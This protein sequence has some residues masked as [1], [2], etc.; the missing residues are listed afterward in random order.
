MGTINGRDFIERLDKLE[1]EIW[2]DGEK[3]KGKISEHPAFKGILRSKAS[4]YDLQNDPVLKDQMTYFL[5]ERGEYVG[6]SYLQPKTKGDLWERRRMMEH[7]ARSTHGLMG[8]SPDYMNTAVM[9]LATSSSL[10]KG[11]E[12]C[13]PENIQSLYERAIEQDLSFTHT[14]IAPQVNRSQDYLGSSEEPIS[15]KVIDRNKE[16]IVIKG[17]RLLATQGGLTDEVLVISAPRLFSDMDEAFAFSIPSNT[18]GLKFICRQSFVGGESSFNHPLSSRY[19]EID[20]VVVFDN[21]LVPWDRVF[22]YDNVEVAADFMNTSSFYPFAYHQVITRQIVKAEF[23]LGVAELLVETINV[24]EYQHI[25]EKLSEIIIGLETLKALLEKSENDAE[26]DEFG[27]MRPSMIPLQVASN[28]SPRIFPRFSEIIQLIGASGMV[29][30]PT[31]KDFSSDIRAD[32]DKYLQGANTNAED[33]VK[34]FR[35]A[36]DLT[37]SSFGTR[38]THYERYFF[39]DPVRLSNVLYKKYLKDKHVENISK[40]LNLKY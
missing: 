8:R 29:S 18:K 28:L 2:F 35:L 22:F 31:E 17:A 11:R 37:M 34:I 24:S 1:N 38:Q 40:L 12:S 4:L 21:V 36:W 19:E 6:L 13:F 26:I 9:S 3:I 27:C 39:G 7:W 16:G 14:F 23:I 25:Q 20:S 32:L 30:L 33:R 15:A 10:L 5:P